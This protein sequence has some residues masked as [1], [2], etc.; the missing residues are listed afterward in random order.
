MKSTYQIPRRIR[1]MRFILRMG[2]RGLFRIFTRLKIEGLENVPASGAYL[3]IFNHVSIYD[4]PLLL[5]LWPTAPEALGADYLW[6]TPGQGLL[7]RLYGAIPIRRGDVDREAMEKAMSALRSGNPLLISPEGT[8]A[9]VPGMQ[10]AKAGVVYILE[11]TGVPV[12][13][14]GV[15]GTD[16][17]FIQHALRGR[18][19]QISI[20]I[21]NPFDLPQVDK[22]GLAPREVRQKQADALMQHLVELL[23]VEYHGFYRESDEA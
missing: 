13:P 4:P 14:V 9:H 2:L 1:W 21:G 5:S 15:T 23:P 17:A 7:A 19:P 22:I 11:R 18:R 12:V 8:R 20:R 10:Q 6:D 3:L 16:D